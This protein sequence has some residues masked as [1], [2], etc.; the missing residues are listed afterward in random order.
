MT[1]GP[2]KAAGSRC[3]AKALGCHALL[4]GCAGLL[5]LSACSA[6]G[7]T[8]TIQLQSL[9]RGASA[10]ITP[11]GHA[12]LSDPDQLAFARQPLGR[13][14]AVYQIR[15]AAEFAKLQAIAPNLTDCPDFTRGIAVAVASE[16]GTPLHGHWP[17]TLESARMVDGAGLIRARFEGGNYLLDAAT[18]V[19]VVYIT[20]VTDVLVVE[21]NGIRY[22]PGSEDDP[23]SSRGWADWIEPAG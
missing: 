21:I 4:L 14:M 10:E 11:L 1:C 12:I 16:I 17:V 13:R 20:G 19:D 9:E 3:G 15:S 23:E 8:R 7:V 5:A 6:P 2:G 18:Y 22:F